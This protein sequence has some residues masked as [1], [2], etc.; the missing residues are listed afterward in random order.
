MLKGTSLFHAKITSEDYLK[1][2]GTSSLKK[3]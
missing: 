1:L 2:K 3:G